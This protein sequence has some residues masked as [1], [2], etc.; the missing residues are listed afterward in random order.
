[1]TALDRVLVLPFAADEPRCLEALRTERGGGAVELCVL[2]DYR[3]SGGQAVGAGPN[4]LVRWLQGS[5]I[6]LSTGGVSGTSGVPSGVGGDLF[7][8][9]GSLGGAWHARSYMNIAPDA[10]VGAD[11]E[12]D[13]VL[14]APP[15]WFE[16]ALLVS[17]TAM[18]AEA[19]A[20]LGQRCAAATELLPGPL[21]A[22]MPCRRGV[23]GVG[24][25]SVGSGGG[26]G[27]G[28][29]PRATRNFLRCLA[30]LR[31]LGVALTLSVVASLVARRTGV[32]L[33]AALFLGCFALLAVLLAAT[34]LCRRGR[35]D[36]MRIADL[37]VS[38]ASL[39]VFWRNYRAPEG[40]LIGSAAI[41]GGVFLLYLVLAR[42]HVR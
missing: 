21:R 38:V 17:L 12:E 35:D 41:G 3:F 26:G 42:E 34:L 2:R 24:A 29:G 25:G 6:A 14:P 27:G 4:S 18:L 30:D 11:P 7:R 39:L 9:V 15:G 5:I 1:M 22:V 10:S 20:A 13:R 23:R 36:R 8:G 40:E 33:A 28:A 31:V 16:S 37:G 19:G 32:L